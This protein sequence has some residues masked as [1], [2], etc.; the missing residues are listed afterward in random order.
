MGMRWLSAAL[1]SWTKRKSKK[2]MQSY[3]ILAQYYDELTTDVPYGTFAGFYE[4]I[5]RHYGV[6]PKTL[7]DLACGTGSLAEILAKKGYDLICTDISPEM[8]SVAADKLSGLANPPL[9][10]CQGMEELDL[11]GTVQGAVCSLDGI[12]YA[13]PENLKERFRRVH[14]FLEP[15]GVFVFDINTPGKLKGLDGQVFIDE[16]DD[17]FCVWRASLER[18]LGPHGACVYGMDIFCRDGDMWD[19]F[20]EEHTEYIYE[21]EE[22]GKLMEGV[23]FSE[24]KVFGEFTLNPPK[25]GGE[26]V[27][28]AGKCCK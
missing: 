17:V 27:F 23:G 24:V 1:K 11:Y 28:L 22:L 7:L 10:I 20:L 26:R 21:P 4:E 5:F 6:S 2:T 13:E 15:G 16:T 25:E 8:L 12:N 9:I 19:R 14:M 18:E 3:D